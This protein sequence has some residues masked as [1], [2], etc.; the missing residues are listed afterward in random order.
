MVDSVRDFYDELA[1]DYHLIYADWP[2]AVRRQGAVLDRQIRAILGSGPVRVLDCAC[3]IGTQAIGLAMRG[4][5]VVATD[6][7][8][9]SVERARTEAK[10]FG[11]E[12]D[13]GIADFRSLEQ[14]EGT[15]DVVIACDNSLPHLVDADLARA[16]ASMRAKLREGGL[17]M[18]SI[19]DYDDALASRTSAT[20]PQVFEG[21][22]GGRRA[23][24]QIWD[25]A[26]DGR[27]YTA[28]LFILRESGE[29]SMTHHATTYRALRRAELSAILRDAGFT[30]V[31]WHT[32][33]E[34]GFFQPLV[35]ARA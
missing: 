25:W 32:P 27:T 14:I 10:T 35:T 9:A 1:A 11:V 6:L 18:A 15:F 30:A 7:S 22:D 8:E 23:V 17:L 21:G 33:A 29:W 31:R 20:E 16:A 24:F 19:R 4:H 2:N 26:R 13:F 28:N 12:I 5:T 3:G 34:A